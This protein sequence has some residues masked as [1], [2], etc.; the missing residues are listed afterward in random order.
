MKTLAVIEELAA[1]G[2]KQANESITGQKIDVSSV[3]D[4]RKLSDCLSPTLLITL[5]SVKKTYPLK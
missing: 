3:D 1:L 4:Q 2:A 5:L